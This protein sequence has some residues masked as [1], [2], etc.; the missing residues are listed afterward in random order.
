MAAF[1]PKGSVIAALDIGSS[2]IACFIGRVRDEGGN[3]DVI[4]LGHQASQGIKSGTVVDLDS[5]EAAIRQ[6]VHA[7]EKMASDVTKGYPL[8][9]VIVNVPGIHTQSKLMSMGVQIMGEAVTDNDI[10]RALAKAQDQA[11]GHDVELIHTIPTAYRIDGHEG[12]REP[13]GL[14]GQHL[15]VDVHMVTGA[16]GPLRNM[17]SCIQSSHLDITALCSAPYASGLACLVEDEMDMGCVVVDMGGGTTSIAVFYGKELIY[18]DA[19][20]VGGQHVTNDIAKGLT[21]SVHAAERM[22]ALYGSAIATATDD[23]DL[24][25][26]HPLGEDDHIQ[27]NHVPRSYLVSIIAPRL[28][29]TLELVR[30]RLNDSGLGAIAGRR[31]VLTGGASQMPGLR[32]LSQKYLEKQVRLGR[33]IRLP[34]LADAVSGPAFSTTAGLLHYVTERADEMPAEIMANVES[35]NMWQ[36]VKMWLHENW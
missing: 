7:A 18:T 30:E 17:A 29:E 33:P 15:D 3:I 23:K 21:T 12:I 13:R 27:P 6:A 20:P 36:R 22:K 8:R 14:F 10:R 5:A 16:M 25:D 11:M 2:K 4:G 1:H 26:V 28:E 9:E 32:E 35:G 24:I 19:I 34:G 31:V